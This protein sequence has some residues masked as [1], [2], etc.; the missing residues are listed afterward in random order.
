[1]AP[2]EH[3]HTA[4]YWQWIKVLRALPLPA[5]TKLLGYALATN[6][7][8]ETGR[9]AFPGIDLLMVQTGVKS[10]QT[11][12]THLEKLRDDGLVSRRFRGSSAGRRGLADEYWLTLHDAARVAAG[13]KPCD[14]GSDDG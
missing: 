2:R 6:A 10:K 4:S 14:C 3:W 12:V 13:K 8:F 9:D 5:T 7:D 11:V 1:M